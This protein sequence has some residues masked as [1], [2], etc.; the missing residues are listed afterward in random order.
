ML[1]IIWSFL[2]PFRPGLALWGRFGGYL[3]CPAQWLGQLCWPPWRSA[4]SGFSHA[5]RNTLN[6][7]VNFAN[8]S[9][10]LFHQFLT[11]QLISPL[12]KMHKNIC[13]WPLIIPSR[14]F[15]L[16]RVLVIRHLICVTPVESL[17]LYPCSWRFFSNLCHLRKLARRSSW[18][19]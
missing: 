11:V 14:A 13:L 2:A 16:L 3:P 1:A 8:P 17:E 15:R 9:T 5:Q 12:S 10:R 7:A 4:H 19:T 6:A 18:A